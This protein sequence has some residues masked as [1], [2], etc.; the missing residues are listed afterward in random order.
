MKR[1]LIIGGTGEARQLAGAAGRALSGKAEVILSLAG[2]RPNRA[3][4]PSKDDPFVTRLGVFADIAALESYLR[5]TAID[6]LVDAS[7]PFSVRIS[8]QAYAACLRRQRARLMLVRPTWANT[9]L[10]AWVAVD[11]VETAARVL[12]RMSRRALLTVGQRHLA[13]FAQVSGVFFVVRLIEEPAEPL[14]FGGHRLVIRGPRPSIEQERQLL[15]GQRIDTLVT[16]DSGG[17]ATEAKVCAA[18]ETGVKVLLIRRPP[19]EPGTAVDNVADALAW[20]A[21]QL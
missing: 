1:I 11:D 8:E 6:L 20:L 15:A 14:P 19:P 21:G 13:P 5:E 9:P 7:H 12:P 2:T 17:G 4:P 3:A 16:L 10:D 18:R